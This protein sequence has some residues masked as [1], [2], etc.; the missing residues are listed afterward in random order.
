LLREGTSTAHATQ[1]GLAQLKMHDPS[2]RMCPK[3][4]SVETSGSH[5]KGPL[6]KYLLGAIGI[7]LYHCM[8]CDARF[9][10]FSRFNEESSQTNKAA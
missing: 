6:E 2:K 4:R 9:Y 10:A 3:C 8:N 5:R 1:E 7:R